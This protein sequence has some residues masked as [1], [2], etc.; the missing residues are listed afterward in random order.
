MS[1]ENTSK[2]WT[3]TCQCKKTVLEAHGK[4]IHVAICHCADCRKAQGGEASTEILVLMRRD[5][6]DSQL[7]EM[8]VVPAEEYIDKVP[9]YFCP[10]CDSCLVGDV[11]PA[12]FNM[13]IV[14]TAR[15]SA[16]VQIGKPDYHM[17]LQHGTTKPENDG[18]PR[19]QGNPEDPHMAALIEGCS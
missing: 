12:G 5:Q 3:I 7:D 13:A 2:G 9:R 4:P 14:P 15:I 6:V 16:D 8:K 11:T 10:S 19:Y 1:A 18:L 17:H